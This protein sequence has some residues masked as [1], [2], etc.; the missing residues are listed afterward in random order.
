MSQTNKPFHLVTCLLQTISAAG[1]KKT[2]KTNKQKSVNLC[3]RVYRA[4][5][6]L[7]ETHTD[8]SM[9]K[10][11]SAALISTGN[12]L[13]SSEN[14]TGSFSKKKKISRSTL[15]CKT[16]CSLQNRSVHSQPNTRTATWCWANMEFNIFVKCLFFSTN[17]NHFIQKI[18][19]QVLVCIMLGWF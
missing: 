19:H 15:C 5:K 18:L 1:K 7:G 4:K 11:L 12:S 14:A 3:L 2:K 9:L 13:S 8:S 6:K 16:T 17:F 10:G